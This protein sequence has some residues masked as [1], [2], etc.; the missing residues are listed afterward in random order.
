[1]LELIIWGIGLGIILSFLTGPVFFAL[2]KTSI[3]KG[4][5]AGVAL[6]CGV[7]V[8]DAI[9]ILITIFGTSLLNFESTYRLP[10]GIIG[11]AV[12]LLIGAYYLIKKVEITYQDSYTPSIKHARYF[13]KGFFMC[14][15]NPFLLLYW[16]SV[17][18][19]VYAVKGDLN[20]H[21]MFVFFGTILIT[22]FSMDVLKAYF[23]YKMRYRIK[24]HV[25][26]KINKV[27]GVLIILFALKIIYNLVFTTSLF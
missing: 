22:L 9:Y 5:I 19:T 12:L 23:S 16:I 11:S 27:A 3:E 8:C 4:F 14:I 26:T 15:F 18:S 25:I 1:M 21:Q 17:M 2:I 24:E 7:V 6:A 10:I 13:F 20:R